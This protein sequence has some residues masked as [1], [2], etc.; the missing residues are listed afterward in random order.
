MMGAIGMATGLVAYLLY[1]VSAH[2]Q[3][4][5]GGGVWGDGGMEQSLLQL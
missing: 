4:G 3:K 1:V 5:S 2:N